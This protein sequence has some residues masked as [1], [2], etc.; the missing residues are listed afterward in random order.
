MSIIQSHSITLQKDTITL[1]PL[2]D[3]HLPLLYRWNADPE[4][5]YWT[6]GGDDPNLSY[7]PETVHQIYGGISSQ[8]NLCFVIEVHGQIIGECWLQKMNIPDVWAMYP[9]GM[10]IRRIDMCIGEKSFWSQGF[11]SAA[12]AILIDFAFSHE[13]VD[14]LHCIND[15]YNHRSCRMMEK[16]H[17]HIIRQVPLPQPSFG[18]YELHWQLTQKEYLSLL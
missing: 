2:S 18:Q 10:D 9:E 15:D 16:N 7:S 5:L 14:I 1:R 8:G 3:E 17:F 6:E 4:V 11:G 12:M 13:N